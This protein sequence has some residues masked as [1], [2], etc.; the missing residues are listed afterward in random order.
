MV[1]NVLQLDLMG[2]EALKNQG[3]YLHEC[4]IFKASFFLSIG[5]REKKEGEDN[6]CLLINSLFIK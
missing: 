3:E 4:H 6:A 5:L 1:L 2:L